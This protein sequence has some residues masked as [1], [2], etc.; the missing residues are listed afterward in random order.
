MA[1]TNS[2]FYGHNMKDNSM[3]A[4]LQD[5]CQKPGFPEKHS[6]LYFYTE[7]AVLVYEVFAVRQ[8]TVEDAAYQNFFTSAAN[9]N[10]FL[11]QM[12]P[13]GV[14]NDGDRVITLSTC[15]NDGNPK[16]LQRFIVQAVLR[17]ESPPVKTLPTP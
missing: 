17:Q 11:R 15:V 14:L 13:G 7:K 12:D 3:F 1:D 8:T 9:Q 4:A 10:A 5:Y 2:I 6:T 16:T